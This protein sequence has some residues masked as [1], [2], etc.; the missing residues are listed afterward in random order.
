MA[1]SI[2]ILWSDDIKVDVLTPLVILR[3]QQEPLR[4]M[5]Q[6]ILEAEITNVISEK[7]IRHNLDL[8]APALGN[9]R[10]RV[11][12][13]THFA[14]QVYPVRVDAA[15]RKRRVES[16]GPLLPWSSPLG[17]ETRETLRKFSE[18]F[19]TKAEPKTEGEPEP[20]LSPNAAT[21]D[22]FIKLL[23]D[24][25]HSDEVRSLIQSLIARSNEERDATKDTNGSEGTN[26]QD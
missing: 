9:Y 10:R 4:R 23:G 3:A 22:Q 17:A 8:V 16:Q 12:T 15:T 14:D 18:D 6:G 2:P 21:E 24:I 7:L 1:T 25:F 5:T 19:P 13:V 20:E 11:V 26:A